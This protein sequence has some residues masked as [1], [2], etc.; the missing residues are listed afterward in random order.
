MAA[1]M[2]PSSLKTMAAHISRPKTKLEPRNGVLAFKFVFADSIKYHGGDEELN[3]P[4]GR[5]R[6]STFVKPAYTV[7]DAQPKLEKHTPVE[8]F[9]RPYYAYKPCS[10]SFEIF[11]NHLWCWRQKQSQTNIIPFANFVSW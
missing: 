7:G 9:L 8:S 11:S 1:F 5:I 3:V 2:A 6:K 10:F 4:K